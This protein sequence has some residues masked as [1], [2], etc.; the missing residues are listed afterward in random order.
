MK[1]QILFDLDG[2]LTDSGE[3]IMHCFELSLARFGLPIPSRQLLRECVGPPLRDSYR[4]FGVSEEI[5]EEAVLAYRDNYNAVGQF[6]NFPYP[7]I[8]ALLERLQKA[9][10]RLY[11]ATSKPEIM[12]VE[13]LTR[14]DMA[15]YFDRICGATVDGS[16]NTKEAVIEYLLR[17]L[18]DRENLL[19]VGDT[20]YDVVGANAHKIP[21]I[22]VTWGYGNREEMQAAGATLVDTMDELFE[23]IE[24]RG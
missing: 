16:R 3:G 22:A 20:I 13:I 10:H 15:K 24:R 21:T 2:T 12:A 7:G 8:E 1:K 14:Y 4:R 9:G 23:E 5:M 6:E 17:Q 11:I 18:P 19:M